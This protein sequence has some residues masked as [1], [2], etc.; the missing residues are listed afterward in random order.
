VRGDEKPRAHDRRREPR[1]D[2]GDREE[3]ERVPRG[4]TDA[5]SSFAISMRFPS[6]SRT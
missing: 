5:Q 4:A 2:R 3:N 6:G 1:G